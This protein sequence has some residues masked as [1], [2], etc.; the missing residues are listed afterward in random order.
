[1]AWTHS[2]SAAHYIERLQHIV[3]EHADNDTPVSLDTLYSFERDA[4]LSIIYLRRQY[5]SQR[6]PNR[7][8]PEILGSIIESLRTR[9]KPDTADLTQPLYDY[10][11]FLAAMRVCHRWYSVA[12]ARAT[13]WTYIDIAHECNPA[14]RILRSRA[15]SRDVRFS[16]DMYYPHVLVDFLRSHGS[17]VRELHLWAQNPRE[18]YKLPRQMNVL[19]ENLQRLIVACV[20]RGSSVVM[21][22]LLLGTTPHLKAIALQRAPWVPANNLPGLTHLY[23]SHLARFELGILLRLLHNTPM[24]QLLHIDECDIDQSTFDGDITKAVPLPHLRHFSLG[25]ISIHS[26]C[27]VL[28]QLEL[29]QNVMLRLYALRLQGGDDARHAFDTF[30]FLNPFVDSNTFTSL[31]I[32]VG[33][34]WRK[35]VVEGDDSDSGG[36][37]FDFVY[38]A[39]CLAASERS[40]L[41]WLPRMPDMV[42]LANIQT[43]H[44]CLRRWDAF[45][46]LALSLPQVRTL[47]VEEQVHIT[48]NDPAFDR[49]GDM[50][51]QI[52]SILSSDA[53]VV[54]PHLHSLRMDASGRLA[55]PKFLLSSVRKRHLDGRRLHS[56]AFRIGPLYR[57]DRIAL[58]ETFADYTQYVDEVSWFEEDAFEWKVSE[59]WRAEHDYWQLRP[60]ED[61][62]LFMDHWYQARSYPSEPEALDPSSSHPPPK[63]QVPRK[64]NNAGSS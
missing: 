20:E 49:D 15:A 9:R 14:E 63:D 10:T 61:P 46:V 6:P 31:D 24:L 34:N 43:L 41:S 12:I 62:M 7:L 55:K 44:V 39:Q 64:H 32:V 26:G 23:L 22:S 4:L 3:S 56:L 60:S 5:N 59:V 35:V 40:W 42:S 36:L 27:M 52:R 17:R 38:Q 28:R 33:E 45:G 1:M 37:W 13:I 51:Y 16:L 18:M 58:T 48:K 57:Y 11:D 2:S 8:P 21:R 50:C 30:M 54:F 25:H 47:C 19:A 29:P 53:P